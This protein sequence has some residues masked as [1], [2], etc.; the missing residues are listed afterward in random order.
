MK[1]A[2]HKS[3]ETKKRIKEAAISLFVKRGVDATTMREIANRADMAVG[4][5]YY[6]F[7]SKEAIVMEFYTDSQ[8]EVAQK[9][10]EASQNVTDLKNLLSISLKT[11]FEYFAPYRKFFG[12]LSRFASDPRHP[13]SPFSPET[14]LVR[15]RS[16]EVFKEVLEKSKV[17]VPADLLPHLPYLLWLTHMGI[18]FFWLHDESTD[19]QKTKVLLEESLEIIV[20]LVQLARYPLIGSVKKSI[21]QLLENMKFD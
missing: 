8:E 21:V 20:R 4:A 13:L 18:I 12:V 6:Y 19:Q 2:P 11:Q 9:I 10:R 14:E 1:E 15:Q 5:A 3:E 16:I 7:D 17:K